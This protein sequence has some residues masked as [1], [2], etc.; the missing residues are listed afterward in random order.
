MDDRFQDG[1]GRRTAGAMDRARP[2][3]EDA[4]RCR[5]C[6]GADVSRLSCPAAA[7]CSSRSCACSC[8]SSRAVPARGAT[9]L[10]FVIRRGVT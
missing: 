1:N 5:A 10:N 4:V 6:S 7:A 3:A 2:S 8:M 9:I